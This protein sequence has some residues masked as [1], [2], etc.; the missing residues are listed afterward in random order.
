MFFALA[1]LFYKYK[2][3]DISV[4]IFV[5]VLSYIVSIALLVSMAPVYNHVQIIDFRQN[6][7]LMKESQIALTFY[8]MTAYSSKGIPFRVFSIL[9][10]F[11]SLISVLAN[12]LFV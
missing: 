10:G 2:K 5:H 4:P 6:I 8:Y 9:I 7:A 1:I 11:M 12:Y 3:I